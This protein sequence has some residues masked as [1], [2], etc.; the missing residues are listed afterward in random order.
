MP[1][2][3]RAAHCT[4]TLSARAARTLADMVAMRVAALDAI[5]HDGGRANIDLRADLG[6]ILAA[7]E[8]DRH[9]A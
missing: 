4:F 8:P 1:R 3:A 6:A 5:D 9:G 7:L 2:R